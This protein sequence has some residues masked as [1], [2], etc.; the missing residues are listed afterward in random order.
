LHFAFRILAGIL[1]P[2]LPEVETMRR[3]ILPIVG[4]RIAAVVRCRC[5]RRPIAIT[6]GLSSF[7]R[8]VVGACIQRVTRLGKR[9]LVWVEGDQ[10]ITFEPRMTGLVLL[11]DPPGREHLRFR[12]D[13]RGAA[14]AHLWYWDRRGL[15]SVRLLHRHEVEG[16]WGPPRLGPDALTLTADQLQ[17]CLGH[18]RTPIKVALLDQT[19]VAGIGNLYASEILHVARLH[20]QLACHRLTPVQWRRLADSMR[21]VL[22]EAISYEGSTLSDGTYRT[23]LNDPGRYQ[24]QHRVYGRHGRLCPQCGRAEIVRIVQAQRSSFFCP[25]CQ[26]HSCPPST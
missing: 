10:A 5:A 21:A 12:L 26:A 7:R 13:L 24:N 1:M 25:I 3:G 14:A 16:Q 19:A 22:E 20:P 15:G 11:T 9:I 6:P 23:A 8:R 17:T 4:G 2:E 18:R